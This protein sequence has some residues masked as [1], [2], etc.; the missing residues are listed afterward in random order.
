M[1]QLMFA[2]AGT[3]THVEQE[4]ALSRL[5]ARERLRY[6]RFSSIR[7]RHT[8][9]VGRTFLLDALQQQLGKFNAQSLRTDG[10]GGIRLLG[11]PHRLSL[12]HCRDLFV[13]SL[14]RITTGVDIENLRSRKL[15]QHIRQLF[16]RSETDHLNGL[17][18][19]ERLD[20]FYIYWTLKEAACKAANISVWEGLPNTCF[21]LA[22]GGFKSQ[23]PFPNGDWQFMS[24][25]IEPHWRV[26][27]AMRDA[28]CAPRIDCWCKTAARQWCRHKLDHQIFLHGK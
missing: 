20:A 22:V 12:S 24:A 4:H 15:L 1:I 17:K 21:E 18:E 9:L 14:S 25:Y 7:R 5:H 19:A 13:V 10:H 16:N 6:E 11:E 28:K 2:S 27:L 3:Y 26:A 23:A 8:W